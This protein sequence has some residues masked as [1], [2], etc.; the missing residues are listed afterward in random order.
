[1][2]LWHSWHSSNH[3]NILATNQLQ[4]ECQSATMPQSKTILVKFQLSKNAPIIRLL[5]GDYYVIIRILLGY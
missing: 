2:T 3:S 5:L 1:M 4:Q